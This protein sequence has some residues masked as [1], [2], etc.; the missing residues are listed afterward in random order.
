MSLHWLYDLIDSDLIS[1]LS[2]ENI[3]WGVPNVWIENRGNDGKVAWRWVSSVAVTHLCSL[4][5]TMLSASPRTG[6]VTWTRMSSTPSSK[7]FVRKTRRY[8]SKIKPSWSEVSCF[9]FLRFVDVFWLSFEAKDEYK[10]FSWSKLLNDNTS[11]KSNLLLLLLHV[12]YMQILSFR[13]H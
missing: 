11:E 2:L 12:D 3:A 9:Y 13:G 7:T 5:F 6:T 10:L 8:A 1:N 4:M